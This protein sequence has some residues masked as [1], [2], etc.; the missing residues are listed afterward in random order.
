[1]YFEQKS[2]VTITRGKDLM[3]DPGF[4]HFS[5]EITKQYLNICMKKYTLLTIN[6]YYIVIDYGPH[7]S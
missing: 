5:T 7:V 3:H 1:M 4:T 2:Y 6:V